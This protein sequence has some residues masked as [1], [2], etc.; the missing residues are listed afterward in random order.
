MKRDRFCHVLRCLHFSDNKSE[1]DKTDGNYDWL[2]KM[3][4]VFDKHSDSCSKYY[5]LT[6]HLALDEII[7]LFKDSHLETVY[8][9]ETQAVWVKALQAVWF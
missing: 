1:P 8:T 6:K 9:R 5:S 4:A 3:W 2:W 7:V